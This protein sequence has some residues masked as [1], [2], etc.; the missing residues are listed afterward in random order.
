VELVHL[1]N[2]AVHGEGGGA[3]HLDVGE[4]AAMVN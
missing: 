1:H 4:G 2:G 3:D